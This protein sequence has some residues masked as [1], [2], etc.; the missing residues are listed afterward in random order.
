MPINNIA[1]NICIESGNAAFAGPP[2]AVAAEVQRLLV[3]A[4]A[5]IV[6]VIRD[7]DLKDP[8]DKCGMLRDVNGN[9]CGGWDVR[10]ETDE[11]G[12]EEDEE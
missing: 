9:V 8:P 3:D 1:V 12:D 10:L 7:T 11:E 6:S 5:R 2:A 4:A